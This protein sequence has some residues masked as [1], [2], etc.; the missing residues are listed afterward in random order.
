[1]KLAVGDAVTKPNPLVLKK[2]E[3]TIRPETGLLK[4]TE[5]LL[6]DNP[7][8]TTYI[9]EPAGG[10]QAV[11][12]VLSIPPEFERK[13]FEKEFFGRRFAAINNKVVTGIPWTPGR[14]E[15]KYTYILRNTKEA[16]TWQRPLDLPCN[17]VTIRI[18]GKSSDE[19][20]CP[21]L[22]RT[23]ADA[24]TVAYASA[25]QEIP[26]GRVLRVELGRLPLP[27]MAYSKWAAVAILLLLITG[28]LWLHFARR[29]PA[30]VEE[31]LNEHPQANRAA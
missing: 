11:T 20:R 18:E 16:T 28:T 7:T 31:P 15:L 4:V 3:I 22:R 17:D 13:T 10:G 23:E 9:G 19:V 12:L 8:R 5:S 6:I 24:K 25:G 29:R 30:T 2:M 26:A 1:M 27:W 14:R 21:L